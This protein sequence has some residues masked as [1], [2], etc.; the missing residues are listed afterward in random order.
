MLLRVPGARSSLGFPGTVTRPGL[1]PCL[2]WRWLPFVATRRQ[3]DP[4][5]LAD[6]H[7][8][9]ISGLS[10]FGTPSLLVRHDAHVDRPR[11]ANASQRSGRTWSSA[12]C[13]QPAYTDSEK[14]PAGPLWNNV[15]CCRTSRPMSTTNPCAASGA[16][17]ARGA[18]MVIGNPTTSI[19]IGWTF[20][21]VEACEAEAMVTTS[22]AGKLSLAAAASSMQVEVAPVSI[23]A[24]PRS[25]AGSGTPWARSCWA[26][27][28]ST[29][30]ETCTTGPR[31]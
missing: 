16:A 31:C 30:T 10:S 4:Q 19:W 26:I 24:N 22:I 6:F 9:S 11:R 12:A 25:G 15:Q 28:C 29:L 8:A 23:R 3:P 7:R 14:L 18:L 5:D 2:N 27:F 1:E 13:R 21:W 17:I 20:C